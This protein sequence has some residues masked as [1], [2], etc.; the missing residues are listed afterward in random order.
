LVKPLC[1]S[2]VKI[3]PNRPAPSRTRHVASGII[4][5]GEA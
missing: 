4:K 5:G 1:V 2:F 3:V